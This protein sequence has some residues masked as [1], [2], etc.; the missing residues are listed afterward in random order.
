MN[1]YVE[2]PLYYESV[3]KNFLPIS[4]FVKK[5]GEFIARVNAS[6]EGAIESFISVFEKYGIS[7]DRIQ[8]LTN[9][10]ICE[11]IQSVIGRL[12]KSDYSKNLIFIAP[13]SVGRI[14]IFFMSFPDYYVELYDSGFSLSA[15]EIA[16][17]SIARD[18]L[19]N[20][21][22]TQFAEDKNA[23]ICWEVSN[24]FINPNPK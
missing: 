20:V 11:L 19:L 18:M 13:N 1:D 15:N 9:S 12:D 2:K 4:Q 10:K 3:P 8:F 17:E 6:E 16:A 22:V 7:T 24:F 21:S 14:K 5:A 23:V